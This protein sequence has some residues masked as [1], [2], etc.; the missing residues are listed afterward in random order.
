MAYPWATGWDLSR[1]GARRPGRA[2]VQI[3]GRPPP[4]SPG[5]MRRAA[6]RA[7]SNRGVELDQHNG[8]GVPDPHGDGG[9]AVEVRLRRDGSGTD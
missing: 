2:E 6:T 3:P 5:L 7:E 1:R 9:H 4:V 8:L